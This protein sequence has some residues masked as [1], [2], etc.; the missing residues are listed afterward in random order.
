MMKQRIACSDHPSKKSTNSRDVPHMLKNSSTENG[1]VLLNSS[2]SNI[3]ASE[4][5]V[6]KRSGHFVHAPQEFGSVT[7]ASQFTFA[8]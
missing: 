7:I 3:D 5:D 8:R 6:K 4:L 2:I 1:P